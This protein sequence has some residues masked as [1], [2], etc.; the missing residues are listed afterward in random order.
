[1]WSCE[2]FQSGG[3]GRSAAVAF[4]LAASLLITAC[5]FQPLYGRPGDGRPAPGD[6]LAAIR[7]LPLPDRIGQRMHNLLRDRLN[8]R[9]QPPDPAYLLN[10]SLTEAIEE[11]GIRKDETASRAN[12]TLRARFSLHDAASNEVLF[13]G[14]SSSTNSYNILENQFATLSSEAD[15]RKRA[16]RELSDDIRLRLGIYFSRPRDHGS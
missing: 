1:M 8:P 4:G 16:L 3:L 14:R 10:V 13:S 2:R 12:L 9:G 7:I 15:A 6:E 5:G 11:L